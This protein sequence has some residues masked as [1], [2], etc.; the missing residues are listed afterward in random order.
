VRLLC[1]DGIVVR[2]SLIIG[3]GGSHHERVVHE[4]AANEREAP[5]SQRKI[6]QLGR[7]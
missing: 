2:T 6:S 3:D 5:S 1:P 7:I 4:L